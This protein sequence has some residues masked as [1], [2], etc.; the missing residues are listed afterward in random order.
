MSIAHDADTCRMSAQIVSVFGVDWPI[1]VRSAGE[2]YA[3]AG[4]FKYLEL[5][6][7]PMMAAFRGTGN[8]EISPRSAKSKLEVASDLFTQIGVGNPC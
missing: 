7:E 4:R 3:R 5:G 6:S 1:T 8:P 2:L